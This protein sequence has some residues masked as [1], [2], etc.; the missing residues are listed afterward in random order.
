MT[1]ST[2]YKFVPANSGLVALQ[3][4]NYILKQKNHAVSEKNLCLSVHN[5]NLTN[6]FVGLALVVVLAAGYYVYRVINE[7]RQKE[8]RASHI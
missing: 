5:N 4:A 8:K 7:E 1:D 3:N 6:A 2:L